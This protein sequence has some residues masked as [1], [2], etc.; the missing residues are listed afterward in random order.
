MRDCTICRFFQ[1]RRFACGQIQ[2]LA[3]VYSGGKFVAGES[4]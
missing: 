4:V 1:K 3:I 2:A